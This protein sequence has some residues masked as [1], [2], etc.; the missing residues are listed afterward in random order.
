ML[1]AAHIWYVLG[2][3]CAILAAA[4]VVGQAMERRRRR[5]IR[6]K[7]VGE[8]GQ[9]VVIK[10]TTI[11]S[12]GNVVHY[13]G[14]QGELREAVWPRGAADRIRDRPFQVLLRERYER[15]RLRHISDSEPDLLPSL[16]LAAEYSRLPGFDAYKALMRDLAGGLAEVASI[17]ESPA[18]EKGRWRFAPMLQCLEAASISSKESASQ[19]LELVVD[20]RRID[21]NW[22]VEGVAPHRLLVIKTVAREGDEYGGAD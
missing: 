19:I 14:R 10:F 4:V 21:V 22:T 8:G 12:F 15:S 5:Q 3:A 2:S 6:E 18:D 1:A 20:G 16:M 7:I 17:E 9:V 11:P 13:I